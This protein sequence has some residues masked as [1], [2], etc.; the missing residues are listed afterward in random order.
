[1]VQMLLRPERRFQLGGGGSSCFQFNFFQQGPPTQR[2]CGIVA[3]ESATAVL[4]ETE[5]LAFPAPLIAATVAITAAAAGGAN[6]FRKTPSPITDDDDVG[7]GGGP[8][9][10]AR[11]AAAAATVG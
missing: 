3:S 4:F 10:V 6:I 8:T 9:R 2:S 7:G 5:T 1:M 11:C